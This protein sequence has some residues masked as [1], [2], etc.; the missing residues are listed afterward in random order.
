MFGAVQKRGPMPKADIQEQTGLKLTTLN[1]FMQPLLEA[2]LLTEEAYGPSSGGRRPVLYDVDRRR[3]A[4][5]GVDISRTYSQVVATDLKLTVLGRRRIPMTA[6]ST[7]ERLLGQVAGIAEE[8]LRQ[9][10]PRTLLLAGVGAVGPLDTAAGVITAPVHFEA[11][12]WKDVPAAAMLGDALGCPAAFDNGANAAALLEAFFGIGRGERNVLYV[13]CGVGI[14]TGACLGGTLLRTP[15]NAEDVFG[16]MVVDIDGLP[17]T[18]GKRGCLDCYAS[19]R[20]VAEACAAQGGEAPAA[21]E[22]PGICRSAERGEEPARSVMLSAAE[23]MGVGLC[24]LINLLNPGAVILSGPLIRHSGLF[25]AQAVKIA[26]AGCN[27]PENTVAFHRGGKFGED[28]M[29]AGAAAFALETA[30][31]SG[32]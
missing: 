6:D 31:R 14:R 3:Y 24:N 26:A 18:C 11:P 28:A 32:R 2:G 10:G 15:G 30:L 9:A 20:A 1:R 29:S 12:G 21:E 17:C 23:Y 4:L 22:Y 27:Y 19:L 16:H 5:V 25:Y 8:L 7:P 13:N